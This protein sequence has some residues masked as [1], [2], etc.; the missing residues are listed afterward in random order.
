MIKGVAHICIGS[1]DLVKTEH[2]YSAVLGM[3]KKFDFVRKGKKAGFYLDSGNGIYVEAFIQNDLSIKDT[4]AIK[5]ICLEVDNIDSTIND[6][7]LKGIVVS[8]KKLGNDNS[9]QAW[10][11]DPDGIKIELHEYTTKSSQITGNDC[12]LE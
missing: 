2:F 10:L 12:I 7:K 9:W 5:H 4:D 11:A 8:D 1:K 3:K 6:L